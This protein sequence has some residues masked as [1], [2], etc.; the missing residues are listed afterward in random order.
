MKF[1]HTNAIKAI[2]GIAFVAFF[3]SACE[4][5]PLDPKYSLGIP[6]YKSNVDSFAVRAYTWTIDS[7]KSYGSY[8]GFNSSNRIPFGIV[9][10]PF[11]GITKSEILCYPSLLDSINTIP[12]YDYSS[13]IDLV[14]RA[15]NVYG[16]RWDTFDIDLYELMVELEGDNLHSSLVIT[17]DMIS[18][19]PI[20]EE[21]YFMFDE[22]DSTV[23][24]KIRLPLK[25]TFSEKILNEIYRYTEYKKDTASDKEDSFERDF[26]GV[27][28]KPKF[29]EGNAG[30]IFQPLIFQSQ[31]VFKYKRKETDTVYYAKTFAI[32]EYLNLFHYEPNTDNLGHLNDSSQQDA[33][34]FLQSL[35]GLQVIVKI[36]SLNSFKQKLNT[37]GG[38]IIRAELIMPIVES[39][40]PADSIYPMVTSVGM[41]YYDAEADSL[42]SLPEHSY[43]QGEG[44]KTNGYYVSNMTQ[45]IMSFMY[46]NVSSTEFHVFPGGYNNQPKNPDVRNPGRTIINS[47]SA[48][49]PMRIKI[50]YTNQPK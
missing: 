4:K 14:V 30:S 10:D 45:Y 42:I 11:F 40:N 20:S 9:N 32:N 16:E 35:A 49:N 18:S 44:W 47:G 27:Y 43:S 29:R 5:G 37:I 38:Q 2:T 19:E 48:A 23:L 13:Y 3:F 26:N 7:V 12:I 17:D 36:D 46:D 1:S 50:Y 24:A 8:T 21:S 22:D 28:F 6:E 15:E 33:S 41:S 31:L 34:C 39:D 25:R